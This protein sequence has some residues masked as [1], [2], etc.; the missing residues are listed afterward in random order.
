MNNLSK[1]LSGV[2]LAV[3]VGI[4]ASFAGEMKDGMDKDMEGAASMSTDAMDKEMK[5]MEMKPGHEEG[6]AMGMEMKDSMK[7]MPKN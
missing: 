3:L 5:P 2:A 4:P 7:M 6:E 1:L